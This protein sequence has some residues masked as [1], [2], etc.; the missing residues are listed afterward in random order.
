[1]SI[2]D[3]IKR[4][5][6]RSQPIK[7]ISGATLGQTFEIIRIQLEGYAGGGK[8]HFLLAIIRHM[9]EVMNIPLKDILVC[10]IDC[11]K[12]GIAPLLFSK[13]I[14][15]E[16]QE[17]IKYAKCNTIFESYEAFKLFEPML[18][19][20]KKST[21]VDGWMYIENMGELW[22]FCQRD[23]VEAAYHI[24]YVQMLIEK[25]E[26]AHAKGKKTLPAL[27]QMLDYRNINPLHNELANKMTRGEYNTCWTCHSKTRKFQEGDMEVEKVMGAGQKDNDAR[28]EFILRMYNLKG[29]FLADSRKLRS[30][31]YNFN[32]LKMSVNSF[33]DF[34]NKYDDMLKKDCKRRGEKKPNFIWTG[35]QT[36]KPLKKTKPKDDIELGEDDGDDDIIL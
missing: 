16:Y 12:K 26:E 23:Y 11:D 2:S 9:H 7:I 15:I 18:L 8:S 4:G 30:L 25:Q 17:C 32:K 3:Q 34:I 28:V 27:D 35:K 10:I 31:E 14:P 1:M 22:Y 19:E 33:T 20:N 36:R 21:G 29:Q 6:K 24:D 13:V 5:S